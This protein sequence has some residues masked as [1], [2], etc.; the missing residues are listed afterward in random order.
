MAAHTTCSRAIRESMAIYSSWWKMTIFAG[1]GG[2]RGP[3]VLTRGGE[4]GSVGS[5]PRG[6]T[7]AW[8]L[9]PCRR[10][11]NSHRTEQRPDHSPQSCFIRQNKRVLGRP[12]SPV[13]SFLYDPQLRA[14]RGSMAMYS[15]CFSWRKMGWRRP[16]V[17]TPV[18]LPR[19]ASSAN[20]KEGWVVCSL[21]F[22]HFPAI[23]SSEPS[24]V[25]TP[26]TLPRVSS[27]ANKRVLGR[28]LSPLPTFPC[29][30]ERHKGG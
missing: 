12:V 24:L 28:L 27:S 22:R 3:S 13:Q 20:K 16:S 17:L 8:P 9:Y 15:T 1:R 10:N 7:L 30:P 25:L 6:A 23:R 29:D 19:V 11:W 2:L 26:I 5:P 4:S 21:L 18:T 14:I